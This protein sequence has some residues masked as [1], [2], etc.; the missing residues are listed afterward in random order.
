[1]IFEIEMDIVGGSQLWLAAL[2]P[3]APLSNFSP[4]C[5]TSLRG[6]PLLTILGKPEFE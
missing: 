3:L 6:I 5:P 2:Q 4:G 1:M